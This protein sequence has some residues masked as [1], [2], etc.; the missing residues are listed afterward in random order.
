M[1]VFLVLISGL[2]FFLWVFFVFVI[3][4]FS[5]YNKKSNRNRGLAFVTMG[6][7]EEALAAL[8]NLESSVSISS[9]TLG[10]VSSVEGSFAFSFRKPFYQ[11]SFCFQR[12]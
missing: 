2:R 3:K 9:L 5:M 4:K 7:H 11:C 10:S 6:S 1:F 12:F 8:N